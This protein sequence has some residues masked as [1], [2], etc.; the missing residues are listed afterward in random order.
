MSAADQYLSL[1]TSTLTASVY[2]ESAWL[3][4]K[5]SDAPQKRIRAAICKALARRGYGLVKFRPFDPKAREN[6]ADWPMFGYSM[7]GKYRIANIQLCLEAVQKENVPGD[8]VECGVWR[9]GASMFAKAVL[10]RLGD[11]SRTVWLCDSFEGMPVQRA[12]DR[13]DPALGGRIAV[14]L[15]QVREN[16]TRFGLL[17][18]H[19]RFVK[20][21]FSDSLASAPIEKISVLRLDGDYYSSTMD[22]LTNLYDKVSPGGFIIVDDYYAFKS[23]EQAITDF[24]EQRKIKPDLVK[25]D[26]I[27]VYFR[28]P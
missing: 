26:D 15:E 3:L 6:G 25:I 17:D 9:G 16:F 7:I 27:G 8:F 13:I 28:K 2:P 18:D 24:C 4:L 19:V 10:N 22:A 21:W 1:L 23:C 14:S 12:E 20:G 11:H 5:A